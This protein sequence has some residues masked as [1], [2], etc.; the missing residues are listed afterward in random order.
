AKGDN[1]LPPTHF[2]VDAQGNLVETRKFATAIGV[3]GLIVVE[4]PDALL[5]CSRERAQDVGKVVHYL[6]KKKLKRLL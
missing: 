4:T 3:E 5:I 6:E 1:L 2:V